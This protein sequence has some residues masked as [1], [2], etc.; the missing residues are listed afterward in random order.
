MSMEY[1]KRLR[2]AIGSEQLILPGAAGAII[3]DKQ[4]LLVKHGA[5]KKWQLPGGLM[6][7]NESIET[8]IQREIKEELNLDME[9][10]KLI[11]VL[12]SPEWIIEFPNGDKIQ[13][14]TFF[15]LLKGDFD[16]C[17]IKLQNE[18][19]Y[20]YNFFPLDAIPEDT[21]ECCK[22]KIKCLKEFNGETILK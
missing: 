20:E 22:E 2:Q 6:E 12:S 21:M 19:I 15:F 11:C 4:V 8:T 16:E 3:K 14:L 10:E 13:Q 9:V 18:E 7:L 1:W 17:D 5:L